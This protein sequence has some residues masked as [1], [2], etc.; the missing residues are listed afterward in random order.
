LNGSDAKLL[1]RPRR[2]SPLL[3]WLTKAALSLLCPNYDAI[4]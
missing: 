1:I 4:K 2:N 3:P